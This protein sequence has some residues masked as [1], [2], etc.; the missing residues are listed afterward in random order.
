[1]N[2]IWNGRMLSVKDIV[3]DELGLR[4]LQ[5]VSDGI[6]WNIIAL[7]AAAF[8]AEMRVRES[9]GEPNIPDVSVLE[10]HL[11]RIRR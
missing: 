8:A 6:G 10:E 7:N 9:A 3:A 11:G 2:V 4:P 1:M 5:T